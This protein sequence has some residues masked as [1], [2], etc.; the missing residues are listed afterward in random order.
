[1]DGIL[2][3]QGRGVLG[4]D[5]KFFGIGWRTGR[6]LPRVVQVFLGEAAGLCRL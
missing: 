2:P 3:V 4:F 5:H 1:M 6:C